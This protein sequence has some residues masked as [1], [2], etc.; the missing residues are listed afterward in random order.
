MSSEKVVMRV[1]YGDPPP[2]TSSITQDFLELRDELRPVLG[3]KFV[4]IDLLPAHRR[5]VPVRKM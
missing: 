3:R 4:Q 5:Q 1:L 2:P